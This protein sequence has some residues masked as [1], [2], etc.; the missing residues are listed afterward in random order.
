M[1]YL[2]T[3][4]FALFLAFASF[5]QEVVSVGIP[6]NSWLVC[7]SGPVYLYGVGAQNVSLSDLYLFIFDS[8]A[9]PTN[10][11]RPIIAPV[12]VPGGSTGSFVDGKGVVLSQGL[13][14]GCSTTDRTYTNSATGTNFI[15]HANYRRWG[16]Q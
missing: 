2:F 6:T 13:A 16:A 1:K 11:Q 12:K 8:A 10:G 14:I 3:G 15:I 7:T 9:S 5:A 4:A